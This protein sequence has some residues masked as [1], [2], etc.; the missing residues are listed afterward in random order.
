MKISL[1]FILD[2]AFYLVAGFFL[3]FIPVNFIVPRPASLVFS[4]T[5]AVI[6]TLFT[7]KISLNKKNQRFSSDRKEKRYNSV[8]TALNLYGEKYATEYFEKAFRAEGY[9]SEKKRG[10]LYIAEKKTTVFFKFGFDGV[11]KTDIVKCFNKIQKAQKAEIYAEN[12]SEEV[13]DFAARFG[14]KIILSDGRKAFEF[15][16]KH[17][18]LPKDKPTLDSGAKK[19]AVDF[20][21]LLDK[22]RAKSYLAFGL[23]FTGLSF[24]APIKGYYLVFGAL[25]LIF[26]LVLKLF[27]KTAT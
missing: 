4:A 6:F 12:F 25:F 16:E 18:L 17:N 5:L 1:S 3:F 13:K 26:A 24:I 8:M 15:L 9:L 27:G 21:R 22:K 23:L 19:P 20:S 10:G 7:V 14:G 2:S 11:T